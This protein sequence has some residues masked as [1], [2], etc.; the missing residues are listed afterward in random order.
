MAA[1]RPSSFVAIDGATTYNFP[2]A[3]TQDGKGQQLKWSTS[4]WQFGDVP[5]I[6][7]KDFG[8]RIPLFPYTEGLGP[9]RLNGNRGTY[10]KSTGDA[11][12][13][14]L[15]VCGP[16][17]TTWSITN[18]VHVNKWVEFDSKFF[19][20][21]D[22]YMYYI[23]LAGNVAVN[24]FV[25]DKDFGVGKA[26]TDATVFENELVVCMGDSENIWRRFK[27]ADTLSGTANAAVTTTNTSLTDTRLTTLTSKYVGTTITCNGKTMLVTSISGGNTFNGTAWSGGGNPGNGF[28]WSISAWA[29]YTDTVR[30]VACCVVDDGFW[31]GNSANADV[32]QALTMPQFASS[33]AASNPVGDP[34]YAIVAT[35]MLDYQ[36]SLW[37]GKT[38]GMYTGDPSGK[39][40][41]Q[42]P[43]LRN[44]VHANNCKGAFVAHGSLW[45]PSAY[46]TLKITYGSSFMNGPE[47]LEL[48][49]YRFWVSGGVEWGGDI[50][51]S[52]WDQDT[53]SGQN[54]MLLKLTR[55]KVNRGKYKIHEIAE[56]AAVSTYGI[57][58]STTP[59]PPHIFVGT[60]FQ[61]VP[62]NSATYGYVLGRGG[63]RVIDD[64]L[65]GFV[66]QS[67]IYSGNIAPSGND[68]TLRS[69]I[70]G[71]EFVT[72]LVNGSS[73]Y[74][75]FY[76]DG[77]AA[78]NSFLTTQDGGGVD[79]VT[80]PTTNYER[81][82]MYAP[83]GSACQFVNVM[84][85][86]DNN[87][88]TAGT[89]RDEIIDAYLFGYL[90]PR[91][92]DRLFV[93]LI[94]DGASLN[95]NGMSSGV[96]LM[97]M[98]R[99]FSG[100][101]DQSTLVEIQLQDYQDNKTT[102]FLVTHVDRT[103]VELENRDHVDGLAI[104]LV[105]VPLAPDYG[106]A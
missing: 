1:N 90:R 99:I 27:D 65:H 8:F 103:S 38:N 67:R 106:V 74:A 24:A 94:A 63:G 53:T 47:I 93:T 33:F 2:I 85:E 51:L 22:R 50:Y 46:G 89:N 31:L 10:T 14:N 82:V 79:H 49:N 7:L 101:C 105:R 66:G 75:Y 4:P 37:V 55:D 77:S 45:V 5:A 78:I 57:G 48:S 100:W 104:T 76:L 36:G 83:S 28:A 29:Q 102:R 96:S 86:L 59:S 68:F 43:Q 84:L 42:T 26:A 54:S 70:E 52:V 11:S 98:H 25:L 17:V 20:I 69:Y 18:S 73:A 30:G 34:S 60:N 97:D 81:K 19:A 35:G 9:S 88:T 15:F 72:K 44:A 71:I 61:P 40:H 3:P 87:G 56:I 64:S 41:N 39:F 80:G 13:D 21:D 6:A 92:T 58:L 16:K 12:Y 23:S 91:Q 32:K 95:G 62:P